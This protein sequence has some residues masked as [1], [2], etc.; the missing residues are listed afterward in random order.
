MNNRKAIFVELGNQR[1]PVF[2]KSKRFLRIPKTGGF[3]A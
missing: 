3:S 1:F 2:Q